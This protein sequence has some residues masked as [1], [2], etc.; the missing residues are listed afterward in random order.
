MECGD[1][2]STQWQTQGA[3]VLKRFVRQEK[4]C[5]TTS[6]TLSTS[7]RSEMVC[8]EALFANERSLVCKRKK[9]CLQT[10]EALFA[11]ERRIF[12]KKRRCALEE[13]KRTVALALRFA[14][15]NFLPVHILANQKLELII[16]YVGRGK[17]I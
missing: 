6:C 8:K 4:R 14:P 2:G 16:L 11:N 12:H 1:C 7:C 10:K 17:G 13:Q 3:R 5:G 15:V 9:P